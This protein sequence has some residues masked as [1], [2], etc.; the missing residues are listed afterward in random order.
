[1]TEAA[2]IL[3]RATPLS[4]VLIDEIG[5][6]TSTFDGLAL[7]WAIARELVE[8][9][10]QPDPVR[11]ALLRANCAAGRARRLRQRPFRRRRAQGSHRIPARGRR[12]AGQPELRLASGE[13]RRRSVGGRAAGARLSVA[14][15]PFQ[16]AP[17]RPGRF[18]LG[19]PTRGGAAAA[20]VGRCSIASPRSTPTPCR[21]ATRT[22][23]CTS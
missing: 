13:A 8:Q 16:R 22:P 2:Y 12:R 17:R 1:M 11:H 5:R 14:T 23:R 4:L 3:N 21:R 9:Q 7:A 15:R 6:G 10:P 19:Q 18:V 20:R